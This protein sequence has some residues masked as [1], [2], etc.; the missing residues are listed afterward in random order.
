MTDKDKGHF[1]IEDRGAVLI[2]RVD[3]GPHAVFGL[4]IPTS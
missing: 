2:V 3:G 4:E 1:E